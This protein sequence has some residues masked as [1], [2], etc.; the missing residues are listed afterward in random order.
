MLSLVAIVPSA[1]LLVPELAGPE[2][3]DADPVRAAVVAAG[4]RLAAAATSWIA[5]GAGEL[6]RSGM[7]F[8][9]YCGAGDFGAYGAPVEI[10]L[11][12]SPGTRPTGGAVLPLSMLV[13]G[14]VRGRA[15]RDDRGVAVTPCVVDPGAT[16]GECAA[17]GAELA[18]QLNALDEPV[19]LL[20]V[21]DGATALTPSAPGGGER[22][23]AIELQARVDDA[24]AHA[25][26]A[27]LAALTAA[28]CAAEGMAGRAAWQVLAAAYAAAGPKPGGAGG[29]GDAVD[30][31]Y[32]AA[33]FGVGYTVALW[34][35]EA[36]S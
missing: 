31:L 30:V 15:D 16:P 33:P 28:E 23:S 22:A 10:S 20:V 24:L 34:K 14:W 12:N 11:G 26:T 8:R 13:A 35:P 27:A 21:A 3:V 6:P 2:A 32:R 25:D 1:P 5:V 29:P 17:I 7:D 19:G 9:T 4:E 18:G 36:T